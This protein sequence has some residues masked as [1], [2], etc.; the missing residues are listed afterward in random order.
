MVTPPPATIG[1]PIPV[2]RVFD[3]A[4][5]RAFYLDYLRFEVVFEHRFEPGL[6]LYRRVRRDSALLDLSEHHGDSTPGSSVW[7]P[8]SD[9]HA[10]HA[11]LH[12]R[13][14]PSL[15]PG[16]DPDAPGGPTMDLID[17]FGNGLRFCQPTG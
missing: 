14:H 2:L 9:V 16:I 17:P 12:H 11:E 15:R 4:L 3:D 1:A 10:L 8:V 13:G 6:P 7:F 5:T